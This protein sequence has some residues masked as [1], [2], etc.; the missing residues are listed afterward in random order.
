[1][2]RYAPLTLYAIGQVDPHIPADVDAA[3]AYGDFAAGVMA[4]IALLA[5]RLR[6]PTGIALVWLFSI[7][8]IGDIA[9]ATWKAVGAEVYKFYMG[10]N[11]Y[12]LNSYVPMLV[13]THVMIIH[14][15]LRRQ[16]SH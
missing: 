3:I 10:W 7:V 5:I 14:R 6:L 2:F 9:F 8:G 1:M 13:V 16:S 12:I 4:L 11:W 15:L